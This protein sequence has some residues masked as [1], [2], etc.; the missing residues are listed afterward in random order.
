MDWLSVGAVLRLGVWLALCWDNLAR[1]HHHAL[2]LLLG[3]PSHLH[4]MLIERVVV[5][6]RAALVLAL[7]TRRIVVA[8]HTVLESNHSITKLH[9]L[10]ALISILRHGRNKL[11]FLVLWYHIPLLVLILG[12]LSLRILKQWY[13]IHD[14]W[15][16]LPILVLDGAQLT[17]WLL[18]QR[19]SLTIN[20]S[21][22]AAS[23]WVTNFLQINSLG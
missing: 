7:L 22:K 11:F 14:L 9:F 13:L 1:L 8:C 21:T 15:G 5:L 2:W 10:I 18:G 12:L 20:D 4:L 17:A 3:T 6:N 16:N 23:G 19:L